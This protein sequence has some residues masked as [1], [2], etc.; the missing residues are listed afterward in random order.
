MEWKIG[1][2]LKDGFKTWKEHWVLITGILLFST[3]LPMVP[4]G[5]QMAVSE[6]ALISKF[7][8][9]LIWGLLI[10]LAEMGFTTI[11][12]KAVKGEPYVFSDFFSRFDLFP[13][14]FCAYVL[15]A[16]A[17]VLGFIFVIIPGII[18]ALKFS[19]YRFFVLE[20]SLEGVEALRKSNQVTYGHKWHLLGFF[21]VACLIN[22]A[23]TLLL[24]IGWLFTAPVTALAWTHLFFILTNRKEIA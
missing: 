17:V 2:L 4:H 6:D 19:M 11:L 23:G 22:F 24:G 12:L 8:L 14:Y 9:L 13:S 20:D 7:I 10:I 18:F 21:I 5:L 16:L 15:N 1:S 3:V